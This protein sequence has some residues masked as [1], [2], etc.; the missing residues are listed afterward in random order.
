[1]Q[2]Q[3]V[4][5]L[6]TKGGQ[7]VS[8]EQDVHLAVA[9]P[10][11]DTVAS[12]A[13][14]LRLYSRA[15]EVDYQNSKGDKQVLFSALPN[16]LI[17][18][19]NRYHNTPAGDMVKVSRNIQANDPLEIPAQCLT[20]TLRDSLNGAKP[21]YQLV[22]VVHHSGTIPTQGH[23]TSYGK[24]A[25]T[26]TW[27]KHDDMGGPRRILAGLQDP[28]WEPVKTGNVFVYVRIPPGQGM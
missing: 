17:L 7:L 24:L 23:Y 16:V 28:V 19:L 27:Y 26:Q 20:Q 22:H 10:I 13:G 4:S 21:R 25:G 3:T 1:M 5:T 6:K 14:A 9:L 11:D 8:S 15:E 12:I 2:S 18:T